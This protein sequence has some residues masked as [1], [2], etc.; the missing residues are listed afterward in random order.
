MSGIHKKHA[1]KNRYRGMAMAALLMLFLSVTGLLWITEAQALRISMKRVVFEGPKRSDIITIMNNTANE[2]TYR[3]GWR[4][5]RMDEEKS[6]VQVKD[7]DMNSVPIKWADDMIR[8]APRR[9]T[10]PPGGSQQ[11]RLLLRRPRDLAAGEYRSHLWVI[12][13]TEA[14]KFEAD[15]S[16]KSGK[17]SFR[18]TMQPALTLP[19][20][21][22]SGD[23]KATASI[24]DAH[25][26]KT[27]DGGAVKF[28]LH[29]D[30]DR[31]LYGDLKVTCTGGKQEYV[32]H[33]IR[34]IAVYPEVNKRILDYEFTYTPEHAAD[35]TQARIEYVAD[36]D[37]LQYSGKVMAQ[38]QVTAGQ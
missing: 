28:V 18:L 1:L 6:L 38:A 19:I 29:R 17:Q 34:G 35:C 31:S 24:T 13:E 30:G 36:S 23:L 11:I 25:L 26:T 3:L 12:T 15:Q 7:A 20:F 22:R 16:Q 33:Q 27:S 2:Q 21:V 9:V 5:Y 4:H 8:F 14:E 37:D 10:V 32:A